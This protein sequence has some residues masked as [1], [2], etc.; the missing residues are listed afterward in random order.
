MAE[1]GRGKGE[2]ALVAALA[3]GMN[4]GFLVLT[5]VCPL[6]MFF[7]MRS[8]GGSDSGDDHTGH[9]CEHDPTRNDHPAKSHS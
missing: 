6:M 7:M 8:M 4:P 2:S 5:A 9:G 3:F 1:H